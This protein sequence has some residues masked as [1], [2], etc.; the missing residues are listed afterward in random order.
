MALRSR[1]SAVL[2]CAIMFLGAHC[3]PAQVL[4][5]FNSTTQD[6]GPHNEAGYAAYD[7]G[8]E[9]SADFDTKSYPVVFPSGPATVTVTPNW[10]N[11]VDNRVRQMLDRATANDANWV[12]NDL[13]LLTDWIGADSRTA[14]GGNGD[15]DGAGTGTPT[16]FNLV[17]GGLPAGQYAWLS[18]HHDNENVWSDFQVEISLDGGATFGSPVD[19]Q[20]TSSTAGGSPASPVIYTG[21]PDPDSRNLPS[22]FTTGFTADGVNDVVLRFAPFVDGVDPIGV[23]KQFFGMNGFELTYIVPVELQFFTID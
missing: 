5:D 3:V 17:I 2:T 13:D 22:T 1:P 10:P 8:H 15:W 21:S 20:M 4:V 23:H 9:V 6:G 14:N 18:Y 12:G 19:L 11:T 7:A 16:Y